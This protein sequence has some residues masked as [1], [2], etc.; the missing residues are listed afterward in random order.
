[1]EA[2]E[3]IKGF[4]GNIWVMGWTGSFG[5]ETVTVRVGEFGVRLWYTSVYPKFFH[6][7]NTLTGS[8]SKALMYE[9]S[10][11]VSAHDHDAWGK[12]AVLTRRV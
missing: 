9:L 3:Q 2:I 5:N 11:E 4:C 12:K 7:Q 10:I 1:M 6:L 8:I